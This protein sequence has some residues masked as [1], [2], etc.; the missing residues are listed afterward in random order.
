[1][2]LFSV[3][4]EIISFGSLQLNLWPKHQ[5]CTKTKDNPATYPYF[6]FSLKNRRLRVRCASCTFY[7]FLGLPRRVLSQL[8]SLN[9][10]DEWPSYDQ[11]KNMTKPR[12]FPVSRLCFGPSRKHQHSFSFWTDL[13]LYFIL[14][15]YT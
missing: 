12:N 14:K 1:M 10:D 3:E 11:N 5:N 8:E 7:N 6:H 13:G 2:S 15:F 9:L 4:I